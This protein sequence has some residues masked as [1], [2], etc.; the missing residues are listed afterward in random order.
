MTHT[1]STTSVDRKDRRRYRKTL[2]RMW[3]DEKFRELS[4][5]QP[6]GQSLWQYLITGPHTTAIPGLFT[7]GE[8]SLTEGLRWS[9]VGFRRAWKE[10]ESRGMAEAD[11]S[12][13]VVWLPNAI[14]HNEPE[15]PNV[16]KG[17]RQFLD[18]IPECD[19]KAKAL[20]NLEGY[21]EAMGEAFAE[22][23]ASA[24]G[25]PSRKALA[26]PSRNQEQE[27]EQEQ[28]RD[29][30]ALAPSRKGDAET[31]TKPTNSRGGVMSGSLQRDHLTHTWCDA[32]Y[33]HCVPERVHVKLVNSLAPAHG[34]DRDRA[35]KQLLLWY[36]MAVGALP[37]DHVMGDAFKFWQA[38]FDA[39]FASPL[40]AGRPRTTEEPSTRKVASADETEARIRRA[41][42]EERRIAA[43]QR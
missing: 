37:P 3:G 40:P 33:S 14:R 23:F 9:L 10:V 18:E 4:R 29:A 11:W 7:A 1:R 19:L 26:H 39:A 24:R 35:G 5:P 8:L 36:P 30:L 22:A 6:N 31:K 42:E 28:E 12:A 20:S 25:K 38:Q 27:Q 43:G 17:W 16:V 15:S 32:G 21:L 41:R 13:R 34:G 2:T